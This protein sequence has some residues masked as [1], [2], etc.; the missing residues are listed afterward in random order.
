MITAIVLALIASQ[1][2]PEIVRFASGELAVGY[3]RG[4]ACHAEDACGEFIRDTS[5]GVIIMYQDQWVYG[6]EATGRGQEVVKRSDA[7]SDDEDA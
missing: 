2:E 7:Q 4:Q 3:E 6:Y 5:S 1:S